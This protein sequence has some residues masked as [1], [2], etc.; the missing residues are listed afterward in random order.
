MVEKACRVCGHITEGRKCEICGS[1][2]L[3]AKWKGVIDVIDPEN[4]KVAADL[5]ITKPGK[6]ALVIE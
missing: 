1:D 4:S 5:K 3:S 6:Y 2:D